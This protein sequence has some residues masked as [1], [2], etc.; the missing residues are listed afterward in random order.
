MLEVNGYRGIYLILA[1]GN[2]RLRV[3]LLTVEILCPRFAFGKT[4]LAGYSGGKFVWL[5]YIAQQ[6]NS[7]LGVGRGRSVDASLQ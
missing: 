5:L 6:R 4:Y 1:I 3:S 7:E 2:G